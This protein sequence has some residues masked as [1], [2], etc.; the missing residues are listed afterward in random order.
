[1]ILN[2]L[3]KKKKVSPELEKV[4]LSIDKVYEELIDRLSADRDEVR[5]K[6]E[7]YGLSTEESQFLNFV[8][9]R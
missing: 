5:T 8:N 2:L 9:D 7:S 4:F 1:M 6:K 3:E